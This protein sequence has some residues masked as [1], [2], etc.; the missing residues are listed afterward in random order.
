[1][2]PILPI[3]FCRSPSGRLGLRVALA[4]LAEKSPVPTD[5]RKDALRL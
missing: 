1:M 2:M 5:R 3:V 4:L